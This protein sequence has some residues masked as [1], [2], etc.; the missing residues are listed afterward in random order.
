MS[1]L[2]V[3]NNYRSFDIAAYQK[4]VSRQHIESIISKP[5]LNIEDFLALISTAAYDLREPIARKAFELTRRHFGNTVVL[6]TPL[7]LSNYCE[8][9][10]AYC[11]FAAHQKIK[12]K[13]L[14]LAEIEQES[15]A[16]A[17]QGMRHILLLT[18]EAPLR[19]GVEYL[20][21]AVEICK[22]HFSSIAIEVLPLST[23][24]YRTL[25]TAGVDALTIYQEVYDQP[26][27][28]SYHTGGPKD[29]YNFRIDA[30]ERALDAGYRSVT[31]GPL[32]GLGEPQSEILFTALH[33]R[34]LQDNYPAAEISV[35]MPRMRPLIGEFKQPYIVADGQ[36][37]QMMMAL[38]LL[39]PTIGI[40]VSTRESQE[41]RSNILPMGVTKMSGGV[42]TAVGG[43]SNRDSDGQFEI[44]DT[45]SVIELRNDLLAAGYQPVMHDWNQLLSR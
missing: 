24:D 21:E 16:I 39:F 18:G 29:D 36:F 10:C 42:S 40:T 30:P 20:R 25:G 44:A 19:A 5:H 32:L 4:Q 31:I 43:H 26:L 22:R 8:N 1:F 27:Y 6:F 33:L 7:Y 2:E 34:Y 38:R 11:S 15:A 23:N 28:H 3:I 17:A 41:F 37:V 9:H 45:R 13:K 12:R 14:S 35:S